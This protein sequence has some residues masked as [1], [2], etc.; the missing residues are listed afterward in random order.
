MYDEHERE[1]RRVLQLATTLLAFLQVQDYGTTDDPD[2]RPTI[3]RVTRDF[4]DAVCVLADRL[5]S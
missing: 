2:V 1:R 4:D 5:N 3:E